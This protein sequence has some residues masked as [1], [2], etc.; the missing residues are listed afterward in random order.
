MKPG[1]TEIIVVMD[2]SGSMSLVRE[3]MQ[4][5][6]DTFMGVQRNAPGDCHVSLYQFD[7]AYETVY[8]GRSI[9][10]I[11]PCYLE[12]RGATALYDAVGRTINAVGE[13]FSKMPDVLRPEKVIF[14]IITDGH[15]NASTEFELSRLKEMISHQTDVYNWQFVYIGSDITT[16]TAAAHLGMAAASYTP[17]AVGVGAMYAAVG[18]AALAYR[19]GTDS[20]LSV[21]VQ[22]DPRK[23]S[24]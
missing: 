6:F 8:E 15:E 10:D 21:S 4:G 14:L 13:R 19:C 17:D 1:L 18:K 23:L 12:P 20:V 11:P 7:K 24:S 2:R 9:H 3:D 16:Q 22:T 5:G